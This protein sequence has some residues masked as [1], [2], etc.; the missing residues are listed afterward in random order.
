MLRA[1][2]AVIAV[3]LAAN[4]HA[5]ELPAPASSN[6]G[7]ARAKA[8]ADAFY[9][10][11]VFP[12]DHAAG[13]IQELDSRDV[14]TA[15]RAKKALFAVPLYRALKA[16]RDQTPEGE[17]GTLDFDPFI[18]GQD[19]GWKYE[20]G[21]AAEEGGHYRIPVHAYFGSAEKPERGTEPVV[22]AEIACTAAD[23][24]FVDFHYPDRKRPLSAILR[25]AARA[26]AVTKKTP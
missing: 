21:E 24:R 9:S 17:T 20:V 19:V 12:R 13:A 5:A 16:E 4:I 8:L 14:D 10:W 11:Y 26:H 6:D 25:S 23:C 1:P 2:A 22:T 15:L 18:G 7:A 3:F